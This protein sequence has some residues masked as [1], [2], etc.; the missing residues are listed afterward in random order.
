MNMRILTIGLERAK[1]L[2][3]DPKASTSAKLKAIFL[4]ELANL[5]YKVSNPELLND[6]VFE[7]FDAII[8][9]LTKMK[10]GDVNY[11]PLFPGFPNKHDYEN[12]LILT[13]GGLIE[14]FG[15][16]D[17]FTVIA[18][19]AGHNG[20][21]SSRPQT[22]K[23]LADGIEDQVSRKSDKHTEWV[24][25]KVTN[26]ITGDVRKYLANNLYA[27]SSIKETLKSDI[28][29]L[30]NHYGLEFLE[31]DKVVFREIKS[32][33]MKYLWTKQDYATL[34][35]FI[36]TPTDILRMF[37]ALT[38]TDISLAETIKFPKL[39]R[40]QRKFVLENIEKSSNIADNLNA[41]KGLWLS[42]GRYIHPGEY[43]SKYPKTFKAFDTL[44]N[45]KVSTFNGTLEKALKAKDLETVLRLSVNRPGVFGRK[46]HEI[47]DVFSDRTG[48]IREF[49]K[50]AEKLELKN[51]LVLEKYFETIND[52]DYK[53][54]INKKGRVIVFKNDKKGTLSRERVNKLVA[55]IKDAIATK[56]T[57]SPLEFEEGTKVW[58]DPALRNY[59][60]PLSLR[61]QTDGLMNYS[62]GTRVKID[63][64]KTLRMFNYWKE[65]NGR[66][67]FDTSVIEFDKDM[68]YKG[69]V[70]YTRL[71]GD[72]IKHSGDITSAPNGASEFIDINFD[73][74]DKDV[75]YLAIQVYVY[76]GENFAQVEK[77]YAGW[78]LRDKTK[79]STM[80][81]DIKTVA[82]KFNM[83]GSGKYAIPMILD[84]ERGEI[85]IIDL[86][87]KGTSSF[88]RVEGAVQ[89]VS[90][91][92]RQLVKMYD[93]KPNM[94]DLVTY[95]I[96][97]SNAEIVATKADADVTYGVEDCT[98]SVDRVDEILAELL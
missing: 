79:A 8:D 80:T 49:K 30:I 70:S 11:V 10:G 35:K 93:T 6:S 37:A 88:N 55:G 21:I 38:D 1:L 43:K 97:G 81:F 14:K 61:K 12:T 27:K 98:Y 52:L 77:S 66:T 18:G 53:T 74:L 60:V 41:Y 78:M 96:A 45:D 50:V 32:Y 71:R 4:T 9:T 23:E 64:S 19:I 42:L 47:I 44:R 87:M 25:L 3:V 48:V 73:K 36:S 39:S 16:L 63:K 86:F 84:V 91:I 72:G 75:K 22:D 51:L 57:E 34:S 29:F 89:D 33:V 40:P 59:I 2:S 76:S 58:I 46:L 31:A 56:V 95:R 62:R 85:V 5:G 83:V 90:T 15:S 68:N 13:I 24:T 82:N 17:Y 94:L 69:H 92:T 20:P 65:A 67:D 28:E 26:D 7:N 54:V